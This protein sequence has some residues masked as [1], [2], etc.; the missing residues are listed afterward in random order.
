MGTAAV[1]FDVDFTLIHPGPRFQASGYADT[2]VRHGLIVDPA[3]FEA[4]VAGAAE[5][6]DSTD[7]LFNPQVYIDSTARIIQL[8][9]GDVA[10]SMAPAREI[11]DDW[12]VNHHFTLYDD[13]EETLRALKARG[14]QLGLI[15]NGHRSLSAFQTHFELEGLIDVTLS[16]RQHGYMKPHAS[17][18]RA[19]LQLAEV[20]AADA[21]MVGDSYAH[22]VAGAES[23][24]MRGILIARGGTA[25][26]AITA[27][28]IQSLAELPALLAI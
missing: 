10:G 12:A 3:R 23:V 25:P 11:Y 16:S 21:V 20:A 19:A 4:A 2:C 22:D 28:V 27:P 9:G 18:F 5:V 1:F 17:I 24:G 7:Q 15:T 6:L 13:V 26:A 8:M 14:L